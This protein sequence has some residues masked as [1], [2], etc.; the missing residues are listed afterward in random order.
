MKSI[1]VITEGKIPT[2]SSWLERF[3]VL[4]GPGLFP[5][6]LVLAPAS[7]PVS[8]AAAVVAAI[9]L[10]AATA[11]LLSA[12]ASAPAGLAA[13]GLYGPRSSHEIGTLCTP[14]PKFP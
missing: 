5:P 14:A 6:G 3:C 11:I 8:A 10:P 1:F 7:A 12:V 4:D 9:P 13:N 2:I